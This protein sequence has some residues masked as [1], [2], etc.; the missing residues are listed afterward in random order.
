[1]FLTNFNICVLGKAFVSAACG[2]RDPQASTHA[3][4]A[5]PDGTYWGGMYGA[6]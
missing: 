2:I 6:D 5:C 4:Y 1:M 3:P